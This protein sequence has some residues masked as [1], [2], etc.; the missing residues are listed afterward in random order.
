M[1]PDAIADELRKFFERLTHIDWLGTAITCAIIVAATALTSFLVTRFIRSIMGKGKIKLPQSTIFVNVVRIAVWTIGISIILG[2]CF[3]INV[4]ALFTALGIGGIAISLGFQDTLSNLIG[5]LQVSIAGLVKPGDHIAVGA[6]SGVVRDVTWRHTSIV[7]GSGQI[8]VIPNSVINN[9]ALIKL[10]PVSY[11]SVPL[12]VTT[13]PEQGG[14][15]A[16]ATDM[17]NAANQAFLGASIPMKKAAKVT[18]SGM[19]E[20]SFKGSLAF[21]VADSRHASR[22]TDL[23]LRAIA[24]YAHEGFFTDDFDVPPAPAPKQSP[25]QAPVSERTPK[26]RFEHAKRKTHHHFWFR[27][28]HHGSQARSKAKGRPKAAR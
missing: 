23:A 8:I 25:A 11:V 16:V 21:T 17:E 26:Q 18:F 24:P 13:V 4:G 15:D 27:H 28:R 22:A 5:G 2:S 9:Q 7:N 19:G 12:F 20:S 1:D 10:R 3:N 6:N 14:L